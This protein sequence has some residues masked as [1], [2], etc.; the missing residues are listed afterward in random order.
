MFKLAWKNIFRNKRR[1]LLS[2]S[3]IFFAVLFVASMLSLY[4]AM[5]NDMK[6]NT[7]NHFL[8]K[9]D[10]SAEPYPTPWLSPQSQGFHPYVE[11]TSATREIPCEKRQ[12][13]DSR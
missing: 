10:S 11:T 3:A 9:H 2:A 13:E 6:E 8:S 5:V 12:Q 1:S 7:I 4:E